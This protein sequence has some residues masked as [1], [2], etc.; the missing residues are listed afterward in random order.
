MDVTYNRRWWNNF[1]T[2]H[3]AALTPADFDEVTLTAP[4][5]EN[6]RGGG[7]YRV[8]FLVRNARQ[9]VGVADSIHDRTKTSVTKRTTGTVWILSLSARVRDAL[10]LQAGTSTGRGVNDTCD[11]LIGAFRAPDGPHERPR[12]RF[13]HR[14]RPALM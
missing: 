6:L 14:Q 10:F 1:F 8:T 11:I 12:N 2:T 13:G 9:A 5:N 3:N 7:G 4:R